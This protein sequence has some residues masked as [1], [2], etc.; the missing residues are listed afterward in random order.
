MANILAVDDEKEIL[1][2]IKR[3][4]EKTGHRV[5][6]VVSPLNIQE[7]Q[8]SNYDLIL[9]DVMMPDM[10]GYECCRKIRGLVDC[11]IIFLTAKVM[12]TDLITGLRV[13][14][15]DYITKPFGIG[16]LRARGEA[17]LRR[18][19][20][21]KQN[22][23]AISGLRFHLAAKEVYVE[24]EL[25]E[26][27]ELNEEQRVCS[28]SVQKSVADME[29]YLMILMDIIESEKENN[30]VFKDISFTT[31]MA[32]IISDARLIAGQKNIRF[33][34]IQESVPAIIT[35]D[36]TA[37]K[38]GLMNVISNAVVHT[39]TGGEILLNV[40][41]KRKFLYF[42][43]EDSGKGFSREEMKSA[44]EPFYQGEKSRNSREHYGLGLYIVD[45]L[46]KN[47]GGSVKLFKSDK[48]GGAKVDIKIP[49]NHL[50]I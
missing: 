12:E 45:N 32:T 14:G 47:H 37:I 25:I 30:L 21:E 46:V 17:H 8:F 34:L 16:E 13:G 20:R 29:R 42:T 28:V 3:A 48:T 35:V 26:E 31:L 15:D 18:D 33:T 36:E 2:I 41:E 39:P 6:T 11:P 43:V 24:A 19:H 5:T 7:N 23:F 38:R 4:L 10:D 40:S 44:L 9:L 27:T 50:L 1:M 22:V 49:V